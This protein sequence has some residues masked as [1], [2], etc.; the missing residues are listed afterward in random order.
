[1]MNYYSPL[2]I[3]DMKRIR[4]S[5][6]DM[7]AYVLLVFMGGAMMTLC[8][9]NAATNRGGVPGNVWVI[10]LTL[11]IAAFSILFGLGADLYYVS[12]PIGALQHERMSGHLDLVRLTLLNEN[13]IV[14]DKFAFYRLRALRVML[15]EICLRVASVLPILIYAFVSSFTSSDV[16]NRNAPVLLGVLVWGIGFFSEPL[17]RRR[18][19]VRAGIWLGMNQP[20][21]TGAVLTGAGIALVMRLFQLAFIAIIALMGLYSGKQLAT[22]A[23]LLVLGAANLLMYEL[24]GYFALDFTIQRFQR[25]EDSTHA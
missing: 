13:A 16:F 17:V 23:V 3:Q 24:L 9:T 2:L 14:R 21:H 4:W 22:L 15:A 1:M 6:D 12:L 18:G 5:R 25:G 11:F 20:N 8:A 19:L 7:R 10:G